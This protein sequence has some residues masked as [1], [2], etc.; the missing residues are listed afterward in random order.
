MSRGITRP[1][2]PET[3]SLPSTSLPMAL[4]LQSTRKLNDG[5]EIP[6]LG[7][8]TYELDGREAYDAVTWALEA[9]YR[10]IDS[11]TWYENEREV[12]QA[13]RDFC[14]STGTPRSAIFYTTKL[15]LNDGYEPTLKAIQ[16][17]LDE[18]GLEYID[19]YLIHGPLGGPAARKE[20][21]RAICD[22]QKEGRVK[23]I[24]ISTFGVRHIKEILEMGLAVPAVNQIDLHP[25]MIRTEIVNLC[26]EHGISLEAWAPLVRG[27]RFK[28]PSIVSLAK[29]HHKE[30]AQILLRYCLQKG[31]IAIPKSSSRARI[32]SNTNIFDFALDE[33]EV[34]DLDALDEGAPDSP[35]PPCSHT[36]S[37]G[38]VTDWDP[39]E[40]P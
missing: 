8:G 20:C 38:L 40:C 7:F 32:A 2:I 37:A 27:L 31:Y 19:L 18:C 26:H 21:W 25:F 23:S 1:P 14:E 24:G 4:T 22:A 11:A 3:I 6:I 35:G 36:P 12:G 13:I 34:A 30:P 39:T 15:K 29:K 5:N 28:H 9:G 16:F 33:K 17:S 10:H